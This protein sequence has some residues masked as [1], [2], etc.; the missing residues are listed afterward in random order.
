MGHGGRR[1]HAAWGAE[2]SN[3]GWRLA[4]PVAAMLN[5]DRF[6]RRERRWIEGERDMNEGDEQYWGGKEKI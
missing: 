3:G 4:G 5:K 6:L 2:T 1:R